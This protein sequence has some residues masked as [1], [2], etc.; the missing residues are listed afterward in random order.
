MGW[1]P[2]GKWTDQGFAGGV[3]HLNL[4]LSSTGSSGEC[5][6]ANPQFGATRTSLF[7]QPG[8]LRTRSP[9]GPAYLV[10]LVRRLYT[11]RL[12]D[13]PGAIPAPFVLAEK[14]DDLV[15]IFHSLLFFLDAGFR[16]FLEATNKRG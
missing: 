15:G 13:T 3:C 10:D 16:S 7:R 14:F 5:L 6:G 2:P 9:Q 1:H 11:S 12:T 8:E 4:T